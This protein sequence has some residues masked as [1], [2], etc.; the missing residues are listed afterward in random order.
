MTIQWLG[1]ACFLIRNDEGHALLMDPFDPSLGYPVPKA[2]ADIV[3]ISHGHHDH[4]YVDALPAGYRLAADT[5]EFDEF[6]FTVYGVESAHDGEGGAKR[7]PNVI[8]VVES[9]GVRVAH[10][11]DLGHIPTEEQLEQMGK[12]DVLMVPVGGFYTIEPKEAVEVI[13]LVKPRIAIPMHYSNEHGGNDRI[14]PMDAFL[15]LS[16]RACVELGTLEI[17]ADALPEE[18]EVVV[19]DLA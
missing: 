3:T 8:F 7:G 19:M 12:V 10:L 4:N 17:D 1:H 16:D 15:A 9:D 6:G 14:K 2:E 5:A 13:D 11:G 18:D